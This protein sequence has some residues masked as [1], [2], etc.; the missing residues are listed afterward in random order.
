MIAVYHLN[1]ADTLT[2]AHER[3]VF[4]RT[5]ALV[6]AFGGAVR[7]AKSRGKPPQGR[8]PGD[9]TQGPQR[10]KPAYFLHRK[11]RDQTFPKEKK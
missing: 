2:N 8:N 11:M 1:R 6:K 5:G 9:E 10:E 3:A 7:S 4:R